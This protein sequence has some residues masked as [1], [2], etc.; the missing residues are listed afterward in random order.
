MESFR[1][2]F[3]LPEMGRLEEK[4][5]VGKI[6]VREETE[7]GDIAKSIE[8]MLESQYVSRRFKDIMA[9]TRL[10]R[11]EVLI[12]ANMEV[13]R[14]L[15]RILS[16]EEDDLNVDGLS[17][18]EKEDIQIMLKLKKKFIKNPC[19]LA[20]A[21]YDGFMYMYG[22]GLQSLE[23]ESRRE[24]VAIAS[25]IYKRVIEPEELSRLERIKRRLFGR[26]LFV[27]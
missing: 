7:K 14:L 8:K 3:R 1:R 22:L 11:R 20:Y 2:D 18:A 25:G 17:D 4:T 10:T 5:G 21:L 26:V 15:M 13:N 12:L 9:S 16:V 27:E 23:G 6:V 24:A 19:A